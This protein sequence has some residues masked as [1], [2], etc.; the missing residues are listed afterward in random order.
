MPTKHFKY[1]GSSAARQMACPDW[2]DAATDMPNKSSSFAEA[3][4]LQHDYMEAILE[5][6]LNF[7]DIDDP[8]NKERCEMALDAWDELCK[9]YQIKDYETEVEYSINSNIGG[10]T[11]VIAWS[12]DRTFI[13]DW[14]FGQGV[15]VAA[16][17]SA[18]MMFYAMCA[19]HKGKLKG[20]LTVVVIQPINSRDD[21]QTLKI[22]DVPPDVFELFKKQY[23]KSLT[24][25]GLNA[26]VHCQF[27]PAASTCPEKSGE[28]RA[29]LMMLPD[30]LKALAANME[31]VK[32]VEDWAKAVKTTAH[33]QLELG[34]RVAGFKLVEKR[35]SR[36]WSGDEDAMLAMLKKNRKLKVGEIMPTKLL[37]VPQME[38]LFKQKGVDFGKVDTYITKT[39]TGT[40]VAAYS[41]PRQAVLS[42]D[43]LKAALGRLA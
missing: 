14:K 18:Q 19:E 28:A 26:G 33:E 35:A 4:T 24:A 34:N 15:P 9:Q 37:S 6:E 27:C 36:K 31:L 21:H 8:D 32:S 20:D 17:G 3:G 29:A 39:S 42:P 13:V 1:G 43:A 22:W 2:V 12:D 23:T 7:W 16:E 41:D 10:T 30:D 40:T 38:K 11:D 5:D 25:S